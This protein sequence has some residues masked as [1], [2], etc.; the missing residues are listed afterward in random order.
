MVGLD[1]VQTSF[2]VSR[3]DSKYTNR[4]LAEIQKVLQT[5]VHQRTKVSA[6]ESHGLFLV[7]AFLVKRARPLQ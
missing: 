3:A 7:G 4:E 2:G 6:T 5:A 1:Q